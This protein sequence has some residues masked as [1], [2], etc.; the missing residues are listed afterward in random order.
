MKRILVPLD[1]SDLSAE[2]LPLAV[3]MAKLYGAEI[4]LAHTVEFVLG[5]DVTGTMFPAMTR[6]EALALLDRFRSQVEGVPV[7]TR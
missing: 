6:E 7:R 2:V 5:P 4:V 3:E 1:G